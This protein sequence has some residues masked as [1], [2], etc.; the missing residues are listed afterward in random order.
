[1][2]GSGEEELLF[3]HSLIEHLV[4]AGSPV[5]RIYHTRAGNSYLHCREDAD[6]EAGV[7][8]TIFEYLPGDDRF[9]WVNPILTEEQLVDS[10]RVLAQFHMDAGGFVPH[11]K[12]A[13]PRILE[14]LPVIA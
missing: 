9:S 4:A 8:Y 2:R 12:R 14:L 13:E 3:E 10:A 1:M 11:G 7:F 6:D 5:A